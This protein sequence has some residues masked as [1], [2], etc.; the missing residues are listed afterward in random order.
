MLFAVCER[1]PSPDKNITQPRDESLKTQKRSVITESQ[2]SGQADITKRQIDT[3]IT[4]T[5][6]LIDSS[7]M[8]D[9][10]T[11]KSAFRDFAKDALAQERE[12]LKKL[13][14]TRAAMALDEKR[15]VSPSSFDVAGLLTQVDLK[16]LEFSK[17]S[18]FEEEYLKQAAALLSAQ[19]KISL[20]NSGNTQFSEALSQAGQIADYLLKK[21]DELNQKSP[22]AGQ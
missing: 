7:L 2:E 5:E 19:K 9:T 8:V 13:D 16:K 4:V 14:K 18:Q 21:V 6:F 3:L 11:S 12:L 10:R 1:P 22:S 15:A 20:Y 17:T